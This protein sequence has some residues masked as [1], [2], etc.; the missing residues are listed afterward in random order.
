MTFIKWKKMRLATTFVFITTLLVG[1][2][3]FFT[4]PADAVSSKTYKVG[5]RDGEVLTMETAFNLMDR[6]V[7]YAGWTC[8][9]DGTLGWD[10]LA[11]GI[12]FQMRTFNNQTPDGTSVNGTLGKET[13]KALNKYGNNAVNG[14]KFAFRRVHTGTS[15]YSNQNLSGSSVTSIPSDT[16]VSVHYRNPYDSSKVYVEF[17]KGTTV[18]CGWMSAG[19]LTPV[20]FP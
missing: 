17:Y 6:Y 18:Y 10:S 13:K 14:N 7:G 15:L 8:N 5:S 12:E 1:V 4:I 20:L 3:S 19:K 2:S 16:T 11:L 9:A